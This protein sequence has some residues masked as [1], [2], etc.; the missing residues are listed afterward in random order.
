MV[1]PEDEHTLTSC[2]QTLVASSTTNNH[3]LKESKEIFDLLEEYSPGF[4]NAV[5]DKERI[6]KAAVHFGGGAWTMKY[7]DDEYKQK[8]GKTRLT[9]IHQLLDDYLKNIQ[10]KEVAENAFLKEL[11]FVAC[12]QIMPIVMAKLLDLG[13]DS[14]SVN[15]KGKSL[16]DIGMNEA[17][18][19]ILGSRKGGP[20]IRK[21]NALRILE[22]LDADL[23]DFPDDLVVRSRELNYEPL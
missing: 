2:L 10:E 8:L 20:D 4:W 13:L 3:K 14:N 18:I 5:E 11:L 21:L 16:K 15:E 1:V 22:L 19:Y 9:L 7:S 6:I 12:K 17:R 23:S